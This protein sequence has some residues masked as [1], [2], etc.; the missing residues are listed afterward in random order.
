VE[1]G[2]SGIPRSRE[3]DAVAAARSDAEGDEAAFVLLN[4]G[5]LIPVHGSE[6]AMEP[7]A[8][9]LEGEIETPYRAVAVRRSGD[10]WA[11]GAVGIEVVELSADT[12]GNELLLTVTQ[13]GERALEVDGRS[14][15]EGIE[16]LEQAVGGR[17]DAYVLRAERLD[18]RLWEIGI[19]PL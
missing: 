2:I 14:T 11:V 3:W 6:E 12:E 1:A 9:A 17:Y 4:D 8:R 5:R 19:D 7:A 10:T 16:A 18:E 13:E 15:I